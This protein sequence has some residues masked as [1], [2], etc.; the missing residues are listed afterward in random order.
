MHDAALIQVLGAIAYG[1]QKAYDKAIERADAVDDDGERRTWRTI[2][3]E[4]LRHHKGFVRRLKALGADP[5]DAMAPYR[6]QLDR[7]HAAPPDPD[8]VRAAVTD[9]LGE[10]IAADLLTWLRT[11]ADGE[12]AAFIDTVLRDEVGHEAHAA[13]EVRRLMADA[14]G[15]RRRGAAAGRAML[16]RMATSGGDGLLPFAAFL[17][18]GRPHELLAG[19]AA[20]YTRRLGLLGIG[21]WPV[22]ERLDLLHVLPRLFPAAGGRSAA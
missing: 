5:D 22:L 8:P 2:A 6:A 12:T 11:V 18:L 10:G 19:I 14:P 20:G 1:E 13:A 9:F 7:F 17:R 15:G 3:A 21:P 16:V 4:E